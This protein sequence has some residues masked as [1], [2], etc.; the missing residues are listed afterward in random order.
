MDELDKL[1][2]QKEK[3]DFA[4]KSSQAKSQL[5][6]KIDKLHDM[7]NPVTER[8]NEDYVLPRKLKK[9]DEVLIVD[10]DK[11]GYVLQEVD[12]S[13][14]VLV[15]AGIM[16][17]RVS[18]KNLR[19]V[20]KNKSKKVKGGTTRRVTSNKVASASMELDLRG[21]MVEEALAELDMFVSQCLMGNA[22]M[23][24]II[25]GKGTGALRS[26]VHVYLKQS[27]YIKSF[28]LGLYGEGESGVTI[29]EFK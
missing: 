14:N 27:K 8:T 7:A 12:N 17:S 26:A 3:E 11:T 6:G 9:G 21:A 4:L 5:R 19:L 23:V 25:H 16:K 13:G 2:K 15:Q 24:T 18:I 22:N 1:R 29:V 28:R 10:I 20:E